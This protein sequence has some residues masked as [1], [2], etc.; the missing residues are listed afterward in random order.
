[1]RT[2]FAFVSFIAFTVSPVYSLSQGSIVVDGNGV[3]LTYT[4]SGAPDSS[5]YTTIFAVHGMGFNGGIFSKIQ[6]LAPK[7]Q[8]RIVA[9]NRR[10]YAGSTPYTPTEL[11]IIAN[12]TAE[13]GTTFYRSV[14]VELLTF[15]DTFIQE[16]DISVFNG[17]NRSAGGVA[18]VSWSIGNIAGL[19]AIAHIEDVPEA[20]KSRLASRMRTFIMQESSSNALGLPAPPQNWVPL[21]ISDPTIPA[22]HQYTAFA[23]WVSA[24][25]DHGDLSTRDPNVISWVVP[26][27]FTPFTVFNMTRN[28]YD[29]IV[30]TSSNPALDAA[31]LALAPALES[32]YRASNFNSTVRSMLPQMKNWFMTGTRSASFGPYCIWVVEDDNAAAGGGFVDFKTIDGVNHLMHWDDPE[33]ALSVYESII[34]S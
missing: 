29:T 18:L 16:H 7:Q 12:G 34:F 10:G 27:S 6:A 19:A 17:D 23:Q 32:N 15:M 11:S 9:V 8:L 30:D 13:Q 26:S 25:F 20:T 28:Q 1:M 4:D 31:Q 2:L 3:Q 22:V 14:G 24:Y 33:L 21:D 5:P